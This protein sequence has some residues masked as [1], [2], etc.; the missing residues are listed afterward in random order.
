MGSSRSPRSGWAARRRRL[1][2]ASIVI[3]LVAIFLVVAIIHPWS[4]SP[5]TPPPAAA[6]KADDPRRHLRLASRDTNQPAD[7]VPGSDHRRPRRWTG[8][9]TGRVDRRAAGASPSAPRRARAM[10]RRSTSTP[11]CRS[12]R[13]R[14]MA[15][16]RR[17]PGSSPV[18]IAS[19]IGALPEIRSSASKAADLCRGLPDLPSGAELLTFTRPGSDPANVEVRAWQE[20]GWHDEPRDIEPLVGLTEELFADDGQNEQVGQVHGGRAARRPLRVP[21]RR[22]GRD[23]DADGLHRPSLTNWT[24]L[25]RWRRSRAR[26]PSRSSTATSAAR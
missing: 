4:G 9:S 25:G 26:R 12:S 14:S 5:P 23:H 6:L 15:R 20:V 8:S 18:V 16:G 1:D 3:G 21:D 13:S 22:C 17:G 7:S 24:I 10:G 2:P 19:E 11:R